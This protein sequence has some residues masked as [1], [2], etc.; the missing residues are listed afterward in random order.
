MVELAIILSNIVIN[1][2]SLSMSPKISWRIPKIKRASP[3][4][5]TGRLCSTFSQVY[6]IGAF[7]IRS[8]S[9]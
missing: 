3:V 4:E 2:L 6:T 7:L 5:K 9:N 8:V 1:P